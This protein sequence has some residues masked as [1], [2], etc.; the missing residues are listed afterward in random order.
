MH[1]TAVSK[2]VRENRKMFLHKGAFFKYKGY[3][4]SNFH[5]LKL[6]SVN[7][8]ELTNFLKDKNIEFNI[9]Y[10]EVIDEINRRKIKSINK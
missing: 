8:L 2:L 1:S 10:Q 9:S 6:K 4:F 3:A 5:K 7:R